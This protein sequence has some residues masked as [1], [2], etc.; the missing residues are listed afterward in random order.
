MKL[1]KFKKIL[2]CNIIISKEMIVTYGYSLPPNV[3]QLFAAVDVIEFYT[4]EAYSGL[5][6]TGVKYNI[7]QLSRVEK[8]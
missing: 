4:V 2:I 6:L 3:L 1:Q 5:D 8:E 7:N